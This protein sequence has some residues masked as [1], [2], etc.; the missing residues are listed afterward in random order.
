MTFVTKICSTLYVK[1]A[2]ATDNHCINLINRMN[3]G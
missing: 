1:M 2:R 3:A